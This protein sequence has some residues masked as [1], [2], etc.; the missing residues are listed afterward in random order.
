MRFLIFSACIQH[1]NSKM[2]ACILR[3]ETH[4][5]PIT[6]TVQSAKMTDVEQKADK[7]L[8]RPD[9][10]KLLNINVS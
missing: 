7:R 4:A 5:Y 10:T 6:R 9:S 3:K 2:S 8:Q 1:R